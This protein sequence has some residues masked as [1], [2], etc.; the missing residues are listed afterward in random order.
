MNPV[1]VSSGSRLHFGLTRVGGTGRLGGLGVMINQPGTQLRISPACELTT[2]GASRVEPFARN[3]LDHAGAASAGV[4]IELLQSPPAHAGLGSGTQLAQSVAAGLNRYLGLPDPDVIEVARVLDRGQRSLVG[5][6]GF[7][8]GGLVVDAASQVSSAS[9]DFATRNRTRPR[10]LQAA[11]PDSWCVVMVQHRSVKR[12]FGAREKAFFEKLQPDQETA[13][14]LER[15][16]EREILPAAREGEFDRFSEN[17]FEF[18]LQSGYYY[19]GVQG[20]PYNGPCVTD[21]V[22]YL[23][24]RKIRGVGQSSWG[25]VVF[26]WC[27]DDDEAAST[28]EETRSRFGTDV[29]VLVSSIRNQP[30]DVIVQ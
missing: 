17:V 14:R 2:C 20:G 24:R 10:L 29:T 18:G 11:I 8:C 19:S 6:L 28:V 21:V 15:L 1:V 5:S 30:A 23:R 16:I 22:N 3:W 26:A 12:T 7:A 27:R 13:S 9:P 25:P 4:K